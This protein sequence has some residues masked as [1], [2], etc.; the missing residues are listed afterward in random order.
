MAPGFCV[1]NE[2]Q[3]DKVR[4][5]RGKN[6]F[7]SKFLIIF[8]FLFILTDITT[9]ASAPATRCAYAR[10]HRRAA[11]GARPHATGNSPATPRLP[12]DHSPATR[13]PL[14]AVSR[15]SHLRR[16]PIAV[17]FTRRVDHDTTARGHG[18]R[19]PHSRRPPASHLAICSP[20][21]GHFHTLSVTLTSVA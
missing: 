1:G 15:A 3:S 4:Q 10:G 20:A 12:T 5:I 8:R 16:R 9:D 13:R 7:E 21:T 6:V 17:E 18:A 14:T 2:A 19:P 11:T